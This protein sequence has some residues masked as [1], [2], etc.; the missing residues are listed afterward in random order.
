MISGKGGTLELCFR[1]LA[2]VPVFLLAVPFSLS[3]L[4]PGMGSTPGPTPSLSAD[5]STRKVA[6][7]GSSA[8]SPGAP[9][10]RSSHARAV[11]GGGGRAGRVRLLSSDNK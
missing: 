10:L 4:P 1:A 11:G 5:V 2:T 3:L 6:A 9:E 7:L 8:A